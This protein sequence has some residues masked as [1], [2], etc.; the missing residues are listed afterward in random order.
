VERKNI[1]RLPEDSVRVFDEPF[2]RLWVTGVSSA[3]HR[4]QVHTVTI[5]RKRVCQLVTGDLGTDTCRSDDLVDAIGFRTHHDLLGLVTEQAL[6]V[7]L[8]PCRVANCVNVDL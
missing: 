3:C 2:F 7:P 6:Q 1:Q 8:I 5:E 4:F